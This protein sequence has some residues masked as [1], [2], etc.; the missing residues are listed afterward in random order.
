MGLACHRSWECIRSV[1]GVCGDASS[2]CSAM[3]LWSS[4]G[5]AV[6]PSGAARLA[7]AARLCVYIHAIGCC[8]AGSHCAP[9][10][11]GWRVEEGGSTKVSREAV[12]DRD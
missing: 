4:D 1:A 7:A 3:G 6:G 2:G 8:C 10:V 9:R 12:M 11:A 5:G